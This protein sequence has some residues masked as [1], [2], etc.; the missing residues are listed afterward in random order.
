M[1]VCAIMVELLSRTCRRVLRIK[2]SVVRRTGMRLPSPAG[3]RAPRPHSRTGV[4][5]SPPAAA[6][7]RYCEGT[8][9]HIHTLIRVYGKRTSPLHTHFCT[10]TYIHTYICS[11][12]LTWWHPERPPSWCKEPPFE[13]WDRGCR[14]SWR[15]E[16][17]KYHRV[18]V[19]MYVCMY[20]C[21]YVCMKEDDPTYFPGQA[22][23]SF[24][25]NL[26]LGLG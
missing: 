9:T 17:I 4:G 25:N 5:Y 15:E 3:R 16:E 12:R 6:A 13:L 20:V 14:C 26:R 2:V 22:V 24:L 8:H 21:I 23:N 10:H 1:C 18:Y 11:G 19:C 7:S